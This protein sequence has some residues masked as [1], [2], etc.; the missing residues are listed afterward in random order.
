[1]KILFESQISNSTNINNTAIKN[2]TI[3]TLSK[4]KEKCDMFGEFGIYVQLILGGLSFLIL[5]R[6]NFIKKFF[7]QFFHIFSS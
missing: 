3:S 4:K 2:Q 1:M 5:I 6:K 7:S